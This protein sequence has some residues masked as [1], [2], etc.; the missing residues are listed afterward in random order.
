MTIQ[1]HYEKRPGVGVLSLSGYLGGEAAARFSGAV[2]WALARGEGVLI[3]DLSALQGWSPWGHDTVVAAAWR[4]AEQG[5]S[6]E[7]AGLPA[8]RTPLPPSQGDPAIRW[9]PDLDAALAAHP[10]PTDESP[11]PANPQHWR[12]AGWQDNPPGTS[13]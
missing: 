2:G 10:A 12:S 1:W 7:L 11:R 9:Y 6:L 5:R 13:G 3:V 8:D 4:L